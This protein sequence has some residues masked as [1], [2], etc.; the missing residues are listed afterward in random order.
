M[1][2]VE[3][4][5]PEYTNLLVRRL[6]G[7]VP[8][9]TWLQ[10]FRTILT[11]HL[12]P[13]TTMLDVGCA[14]GYAYN[15]FRD[16]GISYTGIDVE[17]EYLKIAGE[18]FSDAPD[19]AFLEHD[20]VSAPPPRTA[21]IVFCSAILE[22]CPSLQPAL[23]HLADAAEQILLLRT[24]LANDERLEAVPSRVAA[25]RATHQKYTNQYSFHDVL[26]F[27]DRRGFKTTVYR[28]EYT[29][30]IPQFIEIDSVVRTFYVVHAE[31]RAAVS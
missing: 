16:F 29:S 18:W 1:S 12:Q 15:S 17:P 26:S 31:K 2:F 13:G 10:Q 21:S 6:R 4:T 28:D 5:G 9:L 27:L 30:S 11:P 22:H 3:I 7:D 24:F 19:V 25:Y 20:I 23:G 8:E 14:V